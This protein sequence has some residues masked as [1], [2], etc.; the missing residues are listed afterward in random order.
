MPS[1]FIVLRDLVAGRRYPGFYAED[2]LSPSISVLQEHCSDNYNPKSPQ[3]I[4]L[5]TLFN[6]AKQ[7]RTSTHY[8]CASHAIP[9]PLHNLIHNPHLTLLF[10]NTV[11]ILEHLIHLLQRLARRLGHAEEREQEGEQAEDSEEG[12]CAEARVLD[13][14]RGDETLLGTV[15][16]M[17]KLS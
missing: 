16:A 15:S 12:V 13:K 8:L 6:S 2:F 7:L 17:F 4:A 14:G 10:F 1:F 5:G 11:H 3:I 9:P